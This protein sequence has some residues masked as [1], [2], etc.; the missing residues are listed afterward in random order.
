MPEQFS[1]DEFLH[2][3]CAREGVA[4]AESTHHVRA[5]LDVLTDVVS[6][7][8]IID[9]LDRLPDDYRRLFASGEGKMS[10]Q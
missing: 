6:S 1:S 9:V 4:L 7:D 10:R 5:V 2:R 3:V 8:E